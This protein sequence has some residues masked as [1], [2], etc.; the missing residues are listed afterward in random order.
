MWKKYDL[1]FIFRLYLFLLIRVALEGEG[2]VELTKCI[3][4]A[5]PLLVLTYNFCF[6]KFVLKC[7]AYPLES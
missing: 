6:I 5:T 1:F 2:E 3:K 7:M 4:Q